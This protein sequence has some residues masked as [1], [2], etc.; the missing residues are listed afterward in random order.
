MRQSQR[1]LRC[2]TGIRNFMTISKDPIQRH[3]APV[4]FFKCYH[5]NKFKIE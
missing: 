2:L 5:Q 3:L 1:N 4:E